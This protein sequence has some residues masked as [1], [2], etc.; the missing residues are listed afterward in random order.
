VDLYAKRPFQEWNDTESLEDF[1]ED[2]FPHAKSSLS[3]RESRLNP[4]FTVADMV[5]ICGLEN[6]MD[7]VSGRPRICGMRSCS[8]NQAFIMAVRRA[9]L[10]GRYFWR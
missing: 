1:I 7:S 9:T 3:A 4:F 5:K 6:K 10:I 2:R 8:K